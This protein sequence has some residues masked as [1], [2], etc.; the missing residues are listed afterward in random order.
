VGLPNSDGRGRIREFPFRAALAWS[1]AR[2]D[3]GIHAGVV[4]VYVTM[5]DVI[6][7]RNRPSRGSRTSTRQAKAKGCNRTV[8]AKPLYV[9]PTIQ[10]RLPDKNPLDIDTEIRHARLH[11]V[12]ERLCGTSLIT[13]AN[14]ALMT[15]VLEETEA[16]K[17]PWIWLVL[18]GALAAT[19]LMSLRVYHRQPQ[20]SINVRAW[21]VVTI[22]GAL[23]SGILWG[24]G[25]VL[26]FPVDE[27]SQLL[28]VFLIG[29]MCAGAAS[30]HAAHLPTALAFIGPAAL[31]L[32]VLLAI[33]NSPQ[34]IAAAAMLMIFIMALTFTAR[35]F[36]RHFEQT[37]RLRFELDDTNQRLRKEIG[38]SS[39]YRG[40]SPPGTENGGYRSTHWRDRARL[41]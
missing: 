18:I 9:Y 11:S 39:E 38:R 2:S 40:A 36:N 4:N 20:G 14:A 13:V 17:G 12:F 27:T 8:G 15:A 30:F 29:G 6:S 5:I 19:R 34:R 22:L 28:W 31:P 23:L 35:T 33:Q 10:P 24:G 21:E 1:A 16:S 25:A 3:C 7:N 32:V 26:L 37:L 41:Q